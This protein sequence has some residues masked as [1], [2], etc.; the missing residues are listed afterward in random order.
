LLTPEINQGGSALNPVNSA[1]TDNHFV[2]P[3]YGT[4]SP[5][6]YCANNNKFNIIFSLTKKN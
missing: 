2:E 1:L 5:D 6:P 4:L 3:F